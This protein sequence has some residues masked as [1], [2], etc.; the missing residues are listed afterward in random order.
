MMPS[1]GRAALLALA[2]PALTA[3]AQSWDVVKAARGWARFDATGTATFYDPASKQLITWMKDAGVLGTVDLSKAEM[4]PD[5]WV[6]DDEHIWIMAGTTLKQLGK[7]GKVLRTTS[8]PAG[9]TGAD[10]V[11]AGPGRGSSACQT[12]QSPDR[13]AETSL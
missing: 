9:G 10:R 12:S 8:L 11:G 13:M 1:S 5:R 2:L 7:D 6:V 3:S 4:I